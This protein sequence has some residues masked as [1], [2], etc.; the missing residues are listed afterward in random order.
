MRLLILLLVVFPTLAVHAQPPLTSGVRPIGTRPVISDY[1]LQEV[2]RRATLVKPSLLNL[3]PR[4]YQI[5]DGDQIQ[6]VT[7][8]VRTLS[9]WVSS[10]EHNQTTTVTVSDPEGVVLDSRI[11]PGAYASVELDVAVYG[12]LGVTDGSYS[13]PV[14]ITAQDNG[15]GPRSTTVT[16]T[17]EPVDPPAADCDPAV[18]MG[19]NRFDTAGLLDV[20]RGG[21]QPFDL[22]SCT[23]VVF[24]PRS[25]TVLSAVSLPT[26]IRPYHDV[27]LS[28]STGHL[29][30]DLFTPGQGA[31]A[32]VRG[33]AAPGD[34]LADVL[35]STDF[36]LGAVY[37]G[38]FY[39]PIHAVYDQ[40][41]PD[42]IFD[43][44]SHP[45]DPV[46]RRAAFDAALD[47][48]LGLSAERPPMVPFPFLPGP[49]LPGH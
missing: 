46:G 39:L 5:A 36:V 13:A 37:G 38:R 45:D 1:V 42:T 35:A 40:S 25:G 20:Y 24:G 27:E 26:T 29:L 16:V 8:R 19:L 32:L 30:P 7:D 44:Y 21:N 49:S 47:E 34:A 23:L 11:T 22:S 41:V 4:P 9:F 28:V 15:F 12:G 43:A 6:V 2:R 31:F 48:V 17:V 18:N 3:P 33:T 10:P 14:T